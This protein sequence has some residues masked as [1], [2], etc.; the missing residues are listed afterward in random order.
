M[1][2]F[3]YPPQPTRLWPNAPFL[4]TLYS[5]D[6]WDAEIKYNGWRVLVFL[7]NSLMLYNRQGTIINMDATIFDLCFKGFPNHTVFDGELVHFRTKDTKNTIIIW[8]CM[9]W[10]GKDLR[11]QPLKERRKYFEN[12]CSA[13]MS[14]TLSDNVPRVYKVNVV[15]GKDKR[16]FYKTVVKKNDDLEEGIVLKNIDSVYDYSLR[17]GKDTVNWYKIKKLGDSTLV[18]G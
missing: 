17:T 18:K 7:D 16:N 10:A 15:T 9:F 8:D 3:F 12:M 11:K 1:I 5:S 2:P 13:P 14:L 4:A 6:K